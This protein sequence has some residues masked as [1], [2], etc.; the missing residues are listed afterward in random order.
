MGRKRDEKKPNCQRKSFSRE[1]TVKVR[2]KDG[3]G[4]NRELTRT[5]F[6]HGEAVPLWYHI[7]VFF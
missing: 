5:R 6:S 2:R 1:I 7:I 4:A 3:S